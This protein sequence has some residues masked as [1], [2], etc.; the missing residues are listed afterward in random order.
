[1]NP[2]LQ[3]LMASPFLAV[4]ICSLFFPLK[5]KRVAIK[6]IQNS[7]AW[8][9]QTWYFRWMT[10]YMETM[11]YVLSI[12]ICGMAI[13]GIFLAVLVLTLRNPV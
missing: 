7:P 4:G 12:R 2:V 5:I 11:G 9:R 3:V 1:M 10:A 13:L 6:N 8:I